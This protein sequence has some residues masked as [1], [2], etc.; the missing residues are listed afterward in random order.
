MRVVDTDLNANIVRVILMPIALDQ[1]S[2]ERNRNC[3]IA[4]S[5]LHP[6]PDGRLATEKV[7]S[8][9]NRDMRSDSIISSGVFIVFQPVITIYTEYTRIQSNDRL[10][11]T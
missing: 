5:T 3:C 10:N 9:P 4:A 8:A 6:M 11:K 2:V 7:I 1:K